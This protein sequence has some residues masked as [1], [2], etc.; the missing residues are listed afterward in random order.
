MLLVIDIG[1]TNLVIGLFDQH[2]RGQGRLL[3]SWRIATRKELTSDE[4]AV[5][6]YNLFEIA[7]LTRKSVEAIAICSVV[8]PLNERFET[9][10]QKYFHLDPFFVEPLNQNLI[11]IRYNPPADVGA[12]RIVNALAAFELYGGP[13]IV[14]DFG[15]A[16]TFDAISALGEYLGGVIA[17]GI[18]ISAEALFVRA[19][20]L[21]RIEIKK[22]PQVIGDSTVTSMQ[23]GIFFGYVSLVEGIVR[24][25]QSELQA[26]TVLATGG[27]AWLIGGES[28]VIDK[29][30]E[31][32]TLYG[33]QMFY[34]RR[35]MSPEAAR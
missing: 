29:V 16:T 22:P 19:S 24:R 15:T 8:P 30:E 18:G 20:K 11:P 28:E 31:N 23:S 6:L 32:L 21:P 9:L 3:H 35:Q 17:P 10:S 12:D 2:D 33:L 14:V 1:N 13:A 27:L 26:K 25:M 4:Y 5:L 34:E 7:G